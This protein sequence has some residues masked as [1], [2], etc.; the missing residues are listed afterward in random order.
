MDPL[1]A[2]RS[3]AGMLDAVVAM[4]GSTTNVVSSERNMLC[5][6]NGPIALGTSG[7][8]D[9]LAGIMAGLAARAPPPW[10]RRHGPSIFTARLGGGGWSG[11]GVWACSPVRFPGGFPD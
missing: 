7:S 3:A 10:S 2:A 6:D 5:F 9:V 8:G 1:A 11:T 4:K